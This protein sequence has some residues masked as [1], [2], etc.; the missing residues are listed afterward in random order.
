MACAFIGLGSNLDDPLQ[1]VKQALKDLSE[2]TS[3]A[4]LHASSL[5]RSAPVGPADQPDYINAVARL[6]TSLSALDLL[7]EMQ[8]IEQ[9]H[10]R[11]RGPVQWGPRTLDL[12]LL[13]YDDL[14]LDTPELKLPHPEMNNRGFV[15]VPLHE[16]A[17]D[18]CIPHSGRVENLL[19]RVSVEGLHRLDPTPSDKI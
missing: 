19:L 4:E 14:Q 18:L 11:I 16:I 7:H 6:E 13:L 10:G 12:D 15:L 3:T 17:P 9:R 2:L 1:H 5:F 8:A